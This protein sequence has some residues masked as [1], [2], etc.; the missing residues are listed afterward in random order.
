MQGGSQA[1][2]VRVRRQ[3]FKPR[4]RAEG[5]TGLLEL[6]A[7]A[8]SFIFIGTGINRLVYRGTTIQEIASSLDV[9]GEMF[10]SIRSE[11][12]R[13]AQLVVPGSS[14]K[15]AIRARIELSFTGENGT[16]ASCFIRASP[17]ISPPTP[18]RHGW[19]HF[20][21]W[22]PAPR[23]DRGR[24]CDISRARD[25]RAAQV[26]VV[27]DI[28]GTAGLGSRV[29]FSDFVLTGGEVADMA[30]DHGERLEVVKPGATFEGEVGFTALDPE[31]LGL[32]AFGM[33]LHDSGPILIGRSKYRPR[34]SPD[35]QRHIFGRVVFE[36]MRYKF[37]YYCEDVFEKLMKTAGLSDE[38]VRLNE[39]GD[40]LVE[41]EAAR[42]LTSTVVE[43]AKRRY[44]PL[45]L[46]YGLDEVGRVEELWK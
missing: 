43:M 16:S 24:P 3:P 13:V 35:G 17:P 7:V 10:S 12:G 1:V 25:V 6:R 45:G 33:R 15:G 26:C 29:F 8:E 40:M 42:K 39:I 30:L 4:D 20:A 19:R 38:D 21:I 31:E 2:E 32:L 46:R 18:G 37:A 28:F 11:C 5:L 44:V 27:C 14:V 22:D 36:P 23:E 9:R 41:G 34:I